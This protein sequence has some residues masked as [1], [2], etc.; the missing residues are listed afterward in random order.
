MDAIRSRLFQPQTLEDPPIARFL[1]GNT[2][3]AWVWLVVRLYVGWSWFDAGLHKLTNPAWMS[4]G[5]ALKG[6]W[7]RAVAIP[8]APAKPLI[9]ADYGWF[10]GFL[11]FLLDG[12]HHVWFAK[13]VVWGEVLV[14]VGLIVGAFVGV[15]AA[16][17]AFMNLNFMLAGTAS[18]NPVLFALAIL[19]VLAW[20]VAGYIG[21]DYVLLQWLGTPWRPGALVRRVAPTARPEQAP[22][23]ISG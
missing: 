14:G 4:T 18:T 19:L 1:F 6:F 5:E 16:A 12:N 8:E 21:A 11:Q 10:R 3:T 17:G 23:P 22:V 20:K 13:V 7:V 2:L 15:A 9:A